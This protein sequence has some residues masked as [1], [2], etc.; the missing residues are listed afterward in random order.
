MPGALAEGWTL[1]RFGAV[2]AALAL[3]G[4][5]TGVEKLP[6]VTTPGQSARA[7]TIGIPPQGAFRS[8][9]VQDAA[10]FEGLIGARSDSLIARFGPARIDLAEGDARK[11]QFAGPECV[12]DI[13]LYPRAQGG[14][15]VATHVEARNRKDGAATDRARCIEEV[16][17][18]R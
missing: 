10:G 12:L 17:R 15:A 13:F 9:Q 5:S 14:E 2:A 1:R 8:A 11:L 4:C 3:A 16:E 18:Q 7:Q 6:G